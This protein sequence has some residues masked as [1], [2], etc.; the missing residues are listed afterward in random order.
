MSPPTRTSGVG[1]PRVQIAVT[2]SIATDH[3]MTFRGRFSRL[4]RRRAAR[5]DLAVASSPTTSRS[6]AAASPANI[7]S[8]W[9]TSAQR[10]ILVGRGGRGLRRLPRWLERHGVVTASRSTSR[11]IRHTARFVCTTDDDMAQIATF[12]AGAMSEAAADRARPDRHAQSAASTSCSSA[13]TTPRRCCGTPRSAARAGSR[14]SPTPRSSSRSPTARSSAGSS[15]AP[16]T[17]SPTSTRR[18]SPSRRPAGARTRST[19]RVDDPGHHARQGRRRHPHAR[20]R[21]P[22]TCPSRGDVA[23][24]DPTGVGDAFRAGFLAG[25][26]GGLD[27]ERC[28]QIG[29]D[30]RDLRLETVGTQEYARHPERLPRAARRRLRRRLPP[31]RS[32]RSCACRARLTAPPTADGP[33]AGRAPGT[34]SAARRGAGRAGDDLVGGRRRPRARH[35]CSRP[36]APGLFPMGLG[37]HGGGAD[38]LV[39]ARPARLLRPG[40]LHVSRSLRRSLRP[41]RG[42]ASTPPS[43]RWSPAARTRRG[44]AAGSRRRSPRRTA[45]LHALG[46]AHSV[47]AL[48][49][50][51]ARRRALRRRRSAGCS[52][53]SRCSTRCATRPRSRRRRAGRARPRRRRPAPAGRR[54]VAHA[55]HLR[56]ARVCTEWPRRRAASRADRLADG[57]PRRSAGRPR[58]PDRR[59]VRGRSRCTTRYCGPVRR[60]RRQR[61]R[62][63]PA[64]GTR[65]ARRTGPRGRSASSTDE[66]CPPARSRAAGA[67]RMTGTGHRSPR[68]STST[69]RRRSSAVDA[70]GLTAVA[71]PSCAPHGRHRI[72]QLAHEPPGRR[73]PARV[74]A[75]PR[76]PAA[77]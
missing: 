30:A 63:C 50:R 10:P 34:S 13:P 45:A 53:G 68:A 3:L 44:R 37:P 2:G 18:T 17:S 66:S 9:R 61:P 5:Q 70:A 74:A 71:V 59:S 11:D 14:S 25:L 65:P 64:S 24:V 27:H 40:D 36:T 76:P 42:A 60:P 32:R 69:T 52:R 20:A 58:R 38:R 55:D 22:S 28:A 39:V 48:A 77:A 43:T 21:T 1:S 23:R 31:R 75:R 19:T 67:S 47:E 54:A 35:R 12:Y 6:A 62:V 51:R 56:D 7:A 73:P 15:T 33:P 29:L 8:A 57:P 49:G 46:W 4:P 72:G 41:L 16:T 26:A